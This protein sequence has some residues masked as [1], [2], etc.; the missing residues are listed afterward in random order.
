MTNIFKNWN[1]FDP[2]INSDIRSYQTLDTDM[3]GYSFMSKDFIWICSDCH[4]CHFRD[5]NIFG[6]LFVSKSIQMSHTDIYYIQLT[7]DNITSFLEI[8][9]WILFFSLRC[10]EAGLLGANIK[11]LLRMIIWI[12]PIVIGLRCNVLSRDFIQMFAFK[13]LPLR[14]WD[15]WMLP[16]GA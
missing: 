1:I 16:G 15:R 8:S 4:S 2:N 5:T 3:F 7:Y 14:I 12:L 6:Y 9:S 11:W 13:K 10:D